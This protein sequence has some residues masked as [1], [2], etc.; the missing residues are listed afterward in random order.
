MKTAGMDVAKHNSE[1]CAVR[2][3]PGFF[4]IL[5]LSRSGRVWKGAGRI[6]HEMEPS[7]R[8][9]GCG[10]SIRFHKI[11]APAQLEILGSAPADSA[12]RRF[13][14]PTFKRFFKILSRFF[15]I[16]QDS[17]KFFKI[18]VEDFRPKHAP[19][20]KEGG[21]A[22]LRALPGRQMAG[23]GAGG[24]AGGAGSAAEKEGANGINH[25]FQP[26]L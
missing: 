10:E 21:D 14:R 15:K 2:I 13:P 3:L 24:A 7:E 1:Y 20:G 16:L 8:C 9:S 12:S 5:F 4:Q 22:S 11:Y 26:R 25:V 17:S 6:F 23:A 19:D 18:L